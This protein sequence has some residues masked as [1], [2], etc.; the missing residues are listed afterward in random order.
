MAPLYV[1]EVSPAAKR[2]RNG[3]LNQVAICLG[4]VASIVAGLG[5]DADVTLFTLEAHVR[6][7]V[8]AHP[9]ALDPHVQ[10]PRVSQVAPFTTSQQDAERLWGADSEKELASSEKSD[11]KTAGVVHHDLQKYRR[12]TMTAFLL[13]PPASS[14]VGIN[15][16]VYFSTQIFGTRASRRPSCRHCW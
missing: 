6:R 2:G 4:I 16:V 14:V 3:A 12:A 11:G 15:A 8:G 9:P 13:F 7:G 10:D 1:S 5:V